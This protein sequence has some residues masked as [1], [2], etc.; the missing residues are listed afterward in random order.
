MRTLLGDEI[1][2]TYHYCQKSDKD[3]MN[4]YQNYEFTKEEKEKALS[5]R[6]R[7]IKFEAKVRGK[8]NIKELL[9]DPY[10]P[11]WQIEYFEDIGYI[12]FV[13][14]DRDRVDVYYY[15][16]TEDEAFINATVSHE[17]VVS[18]EYEFFHREKLNLDY[19]KRFLNGE[20]TENDYH[21]PFFFSELA[22]QDFKKY[23]GD[24]I[25]EMLIENYENHV[26]G[27]YKEN[28]KYDIAENRFVK[29]EKVM[30]KTR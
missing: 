19:S 3:K 4:Y 24:N 17:L 21:G 7:L 16:K 14:A 6:N 28:F 23:Y 15:G 13:N 12:A 9:M 25:P 2:D 5:L 18:E 8:C 10:H 27:I 30:Q 22:L 29:K 1:I 20:V 11:E 26:N